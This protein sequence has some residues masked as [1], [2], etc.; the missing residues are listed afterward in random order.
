MR[1]CTQTQPE[2]AIC[3]FSKL[4]RCKK[5]IFILLNHKYSYATNKYPF[6]YY[7][8]FRKLAVQGKGQASEFQGRISILLLLSLGYVF[9][10][11][12]L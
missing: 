10:F 2:M 8:S 9:L 7:N 6:T 4:N 3:L 12:L 1:P 5:P 11:V